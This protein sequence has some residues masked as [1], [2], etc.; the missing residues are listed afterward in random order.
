MRIDAIV[1]IMGNNQ[2][3]SKP[4]G[5]HDRRKEDEESYE[6]NNAVYVFECLRWLD[7]MNV[8]AAKLLS[9]NVT[10][11]HIVGHSHGIGCGAVSLIKAIQ[12]I[13][14]RLQDSYRKQGK[15]NPKIRGHRN[16]REITV[17]TVIGND[18][19]AYPKIFGFIPVPKKQITKVALWR[20]LTPWP[21][22]KFPKGSV[23]FFYGMRQSNRI[24]KGHTWKMGKVKFDPAVENMDVD[25]W[26]LVHH[27]AD[28]AKK[29]RDFDE[30]IVS[31]ELE[32]EVF[33]K[34]IPSRR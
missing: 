10:H 12:K 29:E 30:S 9:Y 6:P 2:D 8:F 14:K 31:R 16:P 28:P 25:G 20:A 18:A 13:N 7:D 21:K 24:P 32:I 17:M 4:N 11:V 15:K 19:V 27:D 1:R 26:K 22:I 23:R 3:W 5:F 34:H 33:N